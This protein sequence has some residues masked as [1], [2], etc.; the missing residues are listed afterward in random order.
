MSLLSALNSSAEA[1]RVFQRGLETSQNNVANVSTPGFA[2]QWPTFFA[3]RFEPDIGIVG[4][5]QAG[6]SVSSR[7]RFAEEA[8]WQQQHGAGQQA[9][10]RSSLEGIEPVFSV[11]EGSGISWSLDQ[12]FQSF[13]QLTVSPNDATARQTAIER[14]GSVAR[15]FNQA[16]SSLDTARE[17]TERQIG[18]VV[19]RINEIGARIARINNERRAN[20]GNGAESGSDAA[21]HQALEELSQLADFS[22]IQDQDGTISV[23]L[24]GQTLFVI[25]DRQY[26][27][28]TNI[29][30][31]SVDIVNSAGQNYRAVS[32]RTAQRVGR[33]PEHDLP[34]YVTDLNTLAQTVADQI[35]TTLA[36]GFDQ[37]GLTPTVSLLLTTP[38]RTQPIR[39]RSTIFNR[40]IWPLLFR[41]RRTATEMQS[42]SLV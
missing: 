3:K 12:L 36:A 39:C 28:G 32:E 7:N 30:G 33:V 29:T 19:N 22:S 40:R 11:Q 24:G 14:A 34:A 38:R 6:P 35:N 2:K 23:Y 8:V 15:N 26:D 21:M 41:Q 18:G 4:G 10:L 17:N 27:I 25:G 9:Q 37:N 1:M 20:A 31:T 5:V 42:P 13:S 16:A